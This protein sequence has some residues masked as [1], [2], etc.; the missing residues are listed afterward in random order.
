MC[1]QQP[2]YN[3]PLCDFAGRSVFEKALATVESFLKAS[4][5]LKG[6]SYVR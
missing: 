1:Y 3:A 2:R 5:G 6:R 4:L